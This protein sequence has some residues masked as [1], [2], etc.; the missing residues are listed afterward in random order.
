MSKS[1]SK[2]INKLREMN[3]AALLCAEASKSIDLFWK[4]EVIDNSALFLTGNMAGSGWTESDRNI[5]LKVL[6]EEFD[7]LV[8]GGW[9]VECKSN[10]L[11]KYR[12]MGEPDWDV[13][14]DKP[15]FFQMSLPLEQSQ[16]PIRKEQII[17]RIIRDSEW[18]VELKELYDYRCC[19][20]NK[21]IFISENQWHCEVHHLRPLGE[22]HN[23]PD[24]KANMM[25]LCPAHH[26]QFDHGVPLWSED[27]VISI[28]H[29]EFQMT[30]RHALAQEY[31]D[32]YRL[33]IQQ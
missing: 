9:F 10:T 33:A 24:E 17:Q 20:C 8:E 7:L 30:I 19:L 16:K 32:Y 13:F 23:G 31:I 27:N 18:V 12:Y 4:L 1:K 14:R 25:V 6:R 3:C 5:I 28:G 26:V 22:P 2:L 29:H 11:A 21:R 15:Q